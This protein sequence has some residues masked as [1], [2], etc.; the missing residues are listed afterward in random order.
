M[1]VVRVLVATLLDW[2]VCPEDGKDRRDGR[3]GQDLK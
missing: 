2:I 3:D 1:W